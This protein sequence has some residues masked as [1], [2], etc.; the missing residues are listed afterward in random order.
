MIMTKEAGL[1]VLYGV[2]VLGPHLRA[3]Y[4]TIT[5]PIHHAFVQVFD[6]SNV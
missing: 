6:R 2:C 3:E 1:G 4:L 5:Q